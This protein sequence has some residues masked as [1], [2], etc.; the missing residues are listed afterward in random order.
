MTVVLKKMDFE[1]HDKSKM[2]SQI[3]TKTTIRFVFRVNSMTVPKGNV[4]VASLNALR[5]LERRC[6]VTVGTKNF[7]SP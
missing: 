6:L 2:Y 1:F 7:A 3:I 5:M 4:A